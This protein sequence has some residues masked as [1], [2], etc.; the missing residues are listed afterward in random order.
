MGIADDVALV[1]VTLP[2][3][4]RILPFHPSNLQLILL[5]SYPQ[6]FL[7]RAPCLSGS[8]KYVIGN[9]AFLHPKILSIMC[10]L[11]MCVR[12]SCFQRKTNWL[13]A[14]FI[15]YPEHSSKKANTNFITTTHSISVLP[16]KKVSSAYCKCILKSIPSFDSLYNHVQTFGNKCKY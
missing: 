7:S 9:N 1:N 10:V 12:N 5:I 6:S 8:P 2:P 11:I 16:N 15:F 13:F 14:K 3:R 4:N